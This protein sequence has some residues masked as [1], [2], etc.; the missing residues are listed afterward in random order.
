MID[1]DFVKLLKTES[2]LANIQKKFI[3]FSENLFDVINIMFQIKEP[4]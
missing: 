3:T 1:G 2:D 4:F